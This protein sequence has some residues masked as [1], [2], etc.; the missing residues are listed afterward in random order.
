MNTQSVSQ[1]D[2]WVRIPLQS[3]ASRDFPQFIT[4]V[5]EMSRKIMWEK[6]LPVGCD[7]V[8][9]QKQSLDS[10]FVACF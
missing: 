4:N 3:R 5:K 10:V 2:L 9:A 1:T 6:D 7:P 8:V